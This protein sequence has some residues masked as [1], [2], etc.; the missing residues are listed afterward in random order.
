M[1]RGQRT[2]GWGVK[3]TDEARGCG[4]WPSAVAKTGH[5]KVPDPLA[6]QHITDGEEEG[7]QCTQGSHPAQAVPAFFVRGVDAGFAAPAEQAVGYAALGV[8][9]QGQELCV[10]KARLEGF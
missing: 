9:R 8:G 4:T 7:G 5:R 10:E 2:A 6:S 3:Q 1:G